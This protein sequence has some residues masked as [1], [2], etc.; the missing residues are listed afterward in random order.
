[1]IIVQIV[2]S[3]TTQ[4]HKFLKKQHHKTTFNSIPKAGYKSTKE[5][6]LNTKY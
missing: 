2:Q 4:N 3:N 1:M 6:E 5:K